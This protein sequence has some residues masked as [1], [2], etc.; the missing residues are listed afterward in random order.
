MKTHFLFEAGPFGSYKKTAASGSKAVADNTKRELNKQASVH[1]YKSKFLDAC[2]P[3]FVEMIREVNKSLVT[4]WRNMSSSDDNGLWPKNASPARMTGICELAGEVSGL[5]NI[6]FQTAVR[7]IYLDPAY[8]INGLYKNA[9][10]IPIYVHFGYTLINPLKIVELYSFLDN[11]LPSISKN[12]SDKL[13]K[14]VKE[15]GNT[16]FFEVPKNIKFAIYSSFADGN[17]LFSETSGGRGRSHIPDEI[18]NRCGQME[19]DISSI[20]KS[21]IL[22]ELMSSIRGLK[23]DGTGV[24]GGLCARDHKT[25]KQIFSLNREYLVNTP[26]FE[27]RHIDLLVSDIANNPKGLKVIDEFLGLPSV[28]VEAIQPSAWSRNENVLIIVPNCL[29]NYSNILT[30]KSE[31][32]KYPNLANLNSSVHF[33]LNDIDDK[34]QTFSSYSGRDIQNH[35]SIGKQLTPA[36]A[37]NEGISLSDLKRR[38]Y[39]LDQNDPKVCK[40]AANDIVDALIGASA[41]GC[42][43]DPMIKKEIQDKLPAFISSLM[44]KVIAAKPHCATSNGM[45]LLCDY[46]QNSNTDNI[47]A[48][49]NCADIA[50]NSK[51]NVLSFKIALDFKLPVAGVNPNYTTYPSR[52]ARQNAGKHYEYITGKKLKIDIK[53]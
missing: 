15:L 29:K 20:Y 49:I 24:A 48:M 11:V 42:Q 30:V 18:A 4:A 7:N 3:H 8:I 33:R 27:V 19:V 12:V 51:K 28:E 9:F 6:D 50:F 10:I 39:V 40:N 37:E 52:G 46:T 47:R 26:I 36:Q 17:T 21:P 31:L 53:L 38:V 16:Q 41:A 5:L 25:L 45:L 1:I 14:V 35:A 23:L 2:T 13:N 22:H 34:A 32:Q 44:N 43:I